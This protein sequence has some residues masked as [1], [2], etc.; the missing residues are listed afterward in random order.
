MSIQ[1]V[2]PAPAG[3]PGALWRATSI[4]SLLL[5]P[6]AAVAGSSGFG[7]SAAGG[8]VSIV[9]PAGYPRPSVT[10]RFVRFE[11]KQTPAR[12]YR[13]SAATGH[14]TVATMPLP[15]GG[16][17]REGE[18]AVLDAARN[19]LLYQLRAKVT[20]D[21]VITGASGRGRSISFQWKRGQA[22]GVGRADLRIFD[23]YLVQTLWI[24]ADT[25]GLK[26]SAVQAYFDSVRARR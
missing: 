2:A 16:Q 9:F 22:S 12:L 13:S 18:N 25:A 14:C 1:S 10:T 3:L 23:G 26:S 20:N 7:V 15:E 5:L 11:G 17:G 21:E 4:A 8:K 6:L 19:E 24:G